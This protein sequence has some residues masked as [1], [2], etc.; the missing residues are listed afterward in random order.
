MPDWKALFAPRVLM[1]DDRGQ[2]RA[3]APDR[4][5]V[6]QR[7]FSRRLN[8]LVSRGQ[9]MSTLRG[10]AGTGLKVWAVGFLCVVLFF[11]GGGWVQRQFGGLGL[12][13]WLVALSFTGQ[14]FS[15]RI[16]RVAVVR[17]VAASRVA[18]GMCGTCGYPLENLVAGQ[19]HCVVCPECGAAWKLSRIVAPF[20][21]AQDVPL[22]P[23]LCR[24]WWR[25][26]V[27]SAPDVGEDDRGR[28]IEVVDSRLAFLSPERRRRLGSEAL[29]N[30]RRAMR[31]AGRGLR[32]LAWL[33]CV[34][35]AGL[36]AWLAVYLWAQMAVEAIVV[37]VLGSAAAITA[38]CIAVFSDVG[39]EIGKR[40]RILL[41]RGECPAC[42][43]PLCTAPDVGDS[44]LTC[45][46]CG[47]GWLASDVG[48]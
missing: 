12:L 39:I 27:G 32:L 42:L 26:A 11:L 2:S 47:A 13:L 44:C 4:D 46:E 5:L 37:A 14:W 15:R 36:S 23:A 8:R 7:Q 22:K 25:V 18:E 19:D 20:W 28:L 40:R 38:A 6:D 1:T 41:Q 48:P 24:H 10:N 33:V 3:I 30:S 29:R 31:P 43:E 21:R 34:L 16:K 9:R 35:S 45:P 17:Q